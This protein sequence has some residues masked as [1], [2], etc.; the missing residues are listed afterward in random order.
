[1]TQGDDPFPE[2]IMVFTI[3]GRD[4]GID[5]MV[6]REI[7]SW[8]TTTPLPGTPRHVL[9]VINIRGTVLPIVDLAARI[10]ALATPVEKREVIIVI[11]VDDRVMGIPVDRVSDI[12][13]VE[14]GN[15]QPVPAASTPGLRR[16]VCGLLTFDDHVVCLMRPRELLLEEMAIP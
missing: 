4:Y 15:V 12:V 5:I 1:M 2:K 16:L 14:E 8:V 3:D 10:S 7:R 6:V 13:N 9:G 11:E